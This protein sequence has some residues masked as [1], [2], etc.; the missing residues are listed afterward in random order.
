MKERPEILGSLRII[1]NSVP[2]PSLSPPHV[3]LL[4]SPPHTHPVIFNEISTTGWDE[5]KGPGTSGFSK[6][7]AEKPEDF[8]QMQAVFTCSKCETRQSKIFSRLAYDQGVVVIKCQVCSVCACNRDK[9]AAR[10]VC[11]IRCQV[12]TLGHTSS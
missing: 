10:G 8:P 9:A 5:G 7:K 12:C 1:A 2:S 3:I 4:T 6:A 11:V